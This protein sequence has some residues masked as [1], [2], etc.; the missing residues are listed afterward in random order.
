MEVSLALGG[1]GI[2]GIAHIGVLDALE[3]AGFTI[4]AIAGTSAGGLIGAVYA[5]GYSPKEILEIIGSL[6][7]DHLYARRPGDAPSLMGYS[8]LAETLTEVLGETRFSDLK[9]PFACTA[10]DLRATQEVYL[11]DGLVVDAVL[12][13]I[14]LPGI[15]PARLSGET[16]LV[17]GGVL[18]PVPVNLARL[19]APR[20]P[21]IAVPLNPAR[22]EWHRIPQLNF[23]PPASLPIPSP[24]VEG[25]ARM[26]IGQSIRVFLHSMDITARM[27]TEMRLEVDKP[28]VILRPD[29]HDHGLL[30]I[31][32]P[33]EVV[34][35][36][37]RAVAEAMPE[38]RRSL[39]WVNTLRRVVRAPRAAQYGGNGQ[40]TLALPTRAAPA[41]GVPATGDPVPG[42]SSSGDPAAEP[43]PADSE[44]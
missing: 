13:T 24:L 5:A 16:E 11:S 14:A 31:V 43:P 36:G 17:D 19:L 18:D 25:F 37:R 15:F 33:G 38:I 30:D 7:P 28:D 40:P 21:V 4:R 39:S 26:R 2:K 27:L 35:A 3:K 23:T 42:V 20:L 32:V 34:E 8:G 12:A 10:V 44:P 9:I 6:K 41:A 22:E 1:G 29:V